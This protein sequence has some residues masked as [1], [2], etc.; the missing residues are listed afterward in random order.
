M[1]QNLVSYLAKRS[2]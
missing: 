1:K 2:T